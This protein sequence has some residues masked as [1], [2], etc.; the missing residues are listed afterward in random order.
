MS[1]RAANDR[2][3]AEPKAGRITAQSRP[4]FAMPHDLE[5]FIRSSSTRPS[6]HALAEKHKRGCIYQ[7][8]RDSDDST[9][10]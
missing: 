6:I 2:A 4:A 10:E 5:M 7:R 8:Q 1:W 3:P 9:P